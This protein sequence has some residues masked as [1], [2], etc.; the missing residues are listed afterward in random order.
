[1]APND[2]IR[3]DPQVFYAAGRECIEAA[4]GFDAFFAV[5]LGGLAECGEMAGSFDSGREW[6][7]AYDE[8]AKDT[9]DTARDLVRALV[10]Y[11]DILRELGYSHAQADGNPD[12]DETPSSSLQFSPSSL[13]SPPSAGGPGQGL[14]DLIG[15][16]LIEE[17]G[18][19]VPDA[20]TDKL[21]K[22]ATIWNTMAT[23][24][25][26]VNSIARLAKLPEKFEALNS[27]EIHYVDDDLRQLHGAATD[28]QHASGE[29]AE[30]CRNYR[31]AM[32][33][34]RGKLQEIL[35]DMVKEL[36]VTLA[37]SAAGSVFS[38]GLAA[39]AG[40]AKGAL[41]VKTAA[42]AITTLVIAW[43]A[44]KV[45]G[46]AIKA[47]KD[48]KAAKTQLQRIRDLVK[49][50]KKGKTTPSAP[51]ISSRTDAEKILNH[52]ATLEKNKKS[53]ISSK[54][55]GPTQAQ[56]EFDEIAQGHNVQTYPNG[57]KVVRLPDGSDVSLRS[58]SDG[59]ITI[60]IQE[61]G[62]PDVKFR[63]DP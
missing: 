6:A 61:K 62:K 16:G 21:D 63:Y 52:G 53:I 37:F 41:T 42:T 47:T 2:V 32:G 17:L 43:K 27:T 59:R 34:L 28:L 15:I 25:V 10:N 58:S 31:S 11:S 22:A 1:M 49:K 9:I 56:K 46:K 54:P 13:Y 4:A 24:D 29:L 18:V 5:A 35:V 39:G 51:T 45:L 7:T 23:G 55:G 33:E 12:N 50:E 57:T 26:V 48:L 14:K 8:R 40:I 36:G 30:T 20:D 60:S 3:V 38:F 44:A 19:P